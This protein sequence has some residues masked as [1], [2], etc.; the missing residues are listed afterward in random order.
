M[1]SFNLT[2]G[3][4]AMALAGSFV[5]GMVLPEPDPI[6]VH[7]L[8]YTG[9]QITQD[10]TIVSDGELFYADWLAEIVDLATGEV[11]CRG[12]GHFPYPA[13]RKAA[14]M[15]VDV[16]TGD[17]GCLERLDPLRAYYP[18]AVWFWGDDQ[19]SHSGEAFYP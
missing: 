18:R 4:P 17:E 15:T 11:V 9:G 5:V 7:D 3:I 8:T 10:R 16:W 12:S 1:S 19:T 13:G 6:E 14:K 2:I